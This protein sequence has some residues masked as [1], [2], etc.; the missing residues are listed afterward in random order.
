[1]YKLPATDV[2]PSP[3]RGAGGVPTATA[4]RS[5]HCSPSASKTKRSLSPPDRVLVSTGFARVKR[6]GQLLIDA[7]LAAALNIPS[8]MQVR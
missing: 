5:V 8:E 1:M 7:I 6:T 3:A 2:M 4:V